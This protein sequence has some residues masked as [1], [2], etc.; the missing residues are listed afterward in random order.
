MIDA[1]ELADLLFDNAIHKNDPELRQ[2]SDKLFLQAI[3]EPKMLTQIWIDA[4]CDISQEQQDK[5]FDDFNRIIKEVENFNLIKSGDWAM[6]LS[7]S[8]TLTQAR[9]GALVVKLIREFCEN[10][11]KENGEDLLRDALG[12]VHDMENEHDYA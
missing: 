7:N 10:H 3:M 11:V 4:M 8:I 12:Y 5:L 9:M 2:K 1:K 6:A